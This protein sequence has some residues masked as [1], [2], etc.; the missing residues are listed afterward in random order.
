ML[1]RSEHGKGNDTR[2]VKGTAWAMFNGASEYYSQYRRIKNEEKDPT[3]RLKSIWFGSTG[4]SI[5]HAFDVALE[6][7]KVG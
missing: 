2:G 6:T 1:F 4:R 3:N 7:I 5:E